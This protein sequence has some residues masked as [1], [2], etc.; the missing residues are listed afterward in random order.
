MMEQPH[1]LQFDAGDRGPLRAEASRTPK[2]LESMHFERNLL[3]RIS[4]KT[5]NEIFFN[6]EWTR[7]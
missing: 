1:G 6:R 3:P 2:W 4:R 5:R 7:T